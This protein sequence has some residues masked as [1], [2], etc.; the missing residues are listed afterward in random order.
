MRIQNFFDKFRHRI[1]RAVCLLLAAAILLSGTGTGAVTVYADEPV[2]LGNT[3]ED[4]TPVFRFAVTSDVHIRGKSSGVLN[5]YEQLANFYSSAYAYSEAQSYNKLDGIFFIGDN[6]QT[7]S[8]EEQTYF[9]NYLEE[10]TKD[11]TFVRAAMGN[12]EFKATGKNYADPAGATAKFLEYSGYESEDIRFELGGYQFIMLSPD[13]YD[14]TNAEY[15]SDGKIAWLEQELALAAAATPDKPI[16]VMQHQPPR[17]TM[18]GSH[19][20]SGDADLTEVLRQYPQVID[21]SGHTHYTMTDPRIIWQGDFTALNTASLCYL[22]LPMLDSEGN[23]TAA[24]ATDN[25]GGWVSGSMDSAVRNAGLFYIVEADASHRIRVL[26]YNMFTQSIWGEP[27]ILDSLDPKD[28]IYTDARAEQAVK[29]E[30]STGASLQLTNN[31]YKN[32]MLSIPQAKCKDVVQS[33]RVE[34]YQKDTLVDT[35]YRLAGTNYGDAAPDQIKAS[36]TGLEAFAKYTAKV[37][38]VSSYGLSS[39]PLT[40][41]FTTAANIQSIEADILDV[42]FTPDGAA[43][44]AATGEALQTVGAPTVTYDESLGQ[45]IA[46]FDGKDDLYSFTDI[47]YWYDV[48]GSG[49]TL[50]TQI[51][52]DKKPSG[53]NMNP[54]SNLQSAGIG[55]LCSTAGKVRFYNRTDTMADYT[56]LDT[57]ITPGKWVH[58]I[59]TYDGSSMRFYLDGELVAEADASG[60]VTV[61]APLARMLCIGADSAVGSYA[62]YFDGKIASAKLYSRSLTQ[63]EIAEIYAWMDG[64]ESATECPGHSEVTAW[65]P[66]TAADWGNGGTVAQGHYVLTENI[67]L[68]NTLTVAQN[69]FVCINLNGFDIT[70]S[71]EAVEGKAYRVFENYGALS[72]LDSALSDGVIS[73]GTAWIH[74]KT[75][76]FAKGGNIYNAANAVFNLYDGILYGGTVSTGAN[77]EA[78]SMGGNIYGDTGSVI[79]ILGGAVLDGFA[80]KGGSY[81]N[82]NYKILYG[83]NISSYGTVNISGGTVSGGKVSLSYSNTTASRMLYLNGGNIAVLSGGALNISGGVV[84]DGL[85]TGTRTNASAQAQVYA[86][87][88]NLYISGAKTTISGGSITGGSIQTTAIG[89]NTGSAVPAYAKSFG[90]SIYAVN[91][92][93][94][95]TGGRITG[96][97]I[98]SIAKANASSTST[99]K[100]TVQAYG[101]N[102]YITDGAVV[103]MT[104]GTVTGGVVYSNSQAGATNALGGNIHVTGTGMLNASGGTISDGT[105]GARGGNILVCDEGTVDLTGDVLVTGGNATNGSNAS[106]Q[107][108]ASATLNIGGNAQLVAPKGKNS[109]YA[110]ANA[111][112]TMYSGTI[113]GGLTMS[114]TS[115]AKQTEF[116]MYGGYVETLFK[117][118]ALPIEQVVLYNGKL[119]CNPAGKATLGTCACLADNGDGTYNIWHEGA[120]D[121]SCAACGFDY[122]SKQ[123][124]MLPGEH[125]LEQ[126]GLCAV[127]GKAAAV[128]LFLGDGTRISMG[129]ADGWNR[130]LDAPD[131]CLRLNVSE[132]TLDIP[133]GK[134][135]TV[136]LNGQT[137]T[138][139]GSGTLRGMDSANDA[140]TLS[141]GAVTAANTVAVSREL[142][143]NG[144]RY[145]ALEESG[146]YTFHRLG[147]DITGMALRPDAAGVY[148]TGTFHG[149]TCVQENI[150]AYGVVLS[151]KAAP[152]LV[153]GKFTADCAASS[154]ND[155]TSGSKATGTL[156]EG[157][158]QKSNSVSENKRNATMPIYGKPYVQLKDGTIL[159]G[160][161]VDLS[162][163]DLIFIADDDVIWQTQS[164]S[165]VSALAQ[166]Y[167][168]YTAVMQDWNIPN[169]KAAAQ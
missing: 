39:E 152:E 141:A 96:G 165:A 28:F 136:D 50:E 83:G 18:N 131:S 37:Y 7:G 72:I 111:K 38:A 1:T 69:T 107:D 76:D 123:A 13:L 25:E 47:A 90:G 163:R 112:V 81:T 80:T 98:N 59:G 149:D 114:A 86:R 92:T 134:T 133:G 150:A 93:V 151:L 6:T 56:I 109:V 140:Y 166:M 137:A 121:G 160:E 62:N 91:S 40:L 116:N 11:G 143:A 55:F 2:V 148:Y 113:T 104:G 139:T 115:S 60:K 164:Q 155:F 21:F 127:C 88:G 126:N 124:V 120:M 70:A 35:I 144:N 87:G 145:I 3:Q 46:D 161:G 36:V 68:R 130:H 167:R 20:I 26:V 9:F 51:W 85:L 73:G 16:F 146:K 103:N 74:G 79:N 15:F 61:P 44:N 101:G 108:S 52:L 122:E 106:A 119:G 100:A 154:F 49:F 95:I 125:T 97:S 48:I 94:D 42:V 142:S 57:G 41:E 14:K 168:D 132:L 110:N 23:Q 30:F 27:Y 135:A 71:G 138:V 105:G 34:I 117:T 19:G 158:L 65:T 128:T 66:V 43:V 8:K 159:L 17:Y 64:G 156:L 129:S 169:L 82:N 53:S 162:L 157:I 75:V 84:A 12:H 118:D 54:L 33:Y 29:P 147:M 31:H 77:A 58:L 32:V 5:G 22:S 102:L 153:N 89:S 45:Y 78:G 10:N 24:K 99:G 4:F 67:P 63:E